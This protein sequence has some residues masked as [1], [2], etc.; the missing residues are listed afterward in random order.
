LPKGRLQ[1]RDLVSKER[2]EE[3]EQ[4]KLKQ[5]KAISGERNQNRLTMK[6]RKSSL[7]RRPKKTSKGSLKVQLQNQ[8]QS[9]RRAKAKPGQVVQGSKR[10]FPRSPLS[11]EEI[12]AWR[13]SWG[14]QRTTSTTRAPIK[15]VQSGYKGSQASRKGK[16]KRPGGRRGG[17]SLKRN[18]KESSLEGTVQAFLSSVVQAYGQDG[19]V[20]L[21]TDNEK[22]KPEKVSVKKK[23]FRK[24]RKF[25]AK[26]TE[27]MIS[28][29]RKELKLSLGGSKK[30]RSTSLPWA[31]LKRLLTKGIRG[32]DVSRSGMEHF[33]RSS[34]PGSSRKTLR[35]LKRQRAGRISEL[36]ADKNIPTYVLPLRGDETAF[37]YKGDTC[38]YI[39]ENAVGKEGRK[40]A[41]SLCRKWKRKNRRRLCS[42]RKI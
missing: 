25:S 15:P 24:L 37:Q 13:H 30:P 29:S 26:N 38:E 16:S 33:V 40:N 9:K 32:P 1:Q 35:S 4:K 23:L 22:K 7:K 18:Q 10:R 14:Q 3:G 11:W 27:N 21:N 36:T 39:F 19:A 20:M 8:S 41:R 34:Y 42:K 5:K 2:L 17:V 6:R 31:K 12:Q 28:L